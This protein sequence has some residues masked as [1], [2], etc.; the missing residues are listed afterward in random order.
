MFVVTFAAAVL[1]A[2]GQSAGEGGAIA[3]GV[4]VSV[5]F[6]VI[7]F[8]VFAALFGI[9]WCVSQIWYQATEESIEGNPFA[10]GQLPPQIIPPR[11]QER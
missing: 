4:I 8:L 3:A 9:S 5:A 6:I 7:C 10:E 2:I 11:E 1:A